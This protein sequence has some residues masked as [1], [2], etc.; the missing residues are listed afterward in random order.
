MV[1]LA[2]IFKYVL[3][4]VYRS[5]YVWTIVFVLALSTFGRTTATQPHAAKPRD[6]LL[7]WVLTC[8]SMYVRI[9][10]TN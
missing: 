5:R 10:A 4:I 2:V 3:T 1:V 9:V 7:S 8:L 6:E